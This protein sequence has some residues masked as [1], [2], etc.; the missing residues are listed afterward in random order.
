MTPET[1]RPAQ[2]ERFLIYGPT[3]LM[4]GVGR[5]NTEL[6][7]GLVEGGHQVKIL[8]TPPSVEL[9]GASNI[10][11]PRPPDGLS[12]LAKWEGFALSHVVQTL[13]EKLRENEGWSPTTILVNGKFRD[14]GPH[15]RDLFPEARLAQ[16]V[17]NL[18]YYTEHPPIDDTWAVPAFQRGFSRTLASTDMGIGVGPLLTSDLLRMAPQ[19]PALEVSPPDC[20]FVPRRCPEA[21]APRRTPPGGGATYPIPSLWSPR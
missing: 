16:I 1:S 6:V 8:T 21:P 7:R 9:E 10:E 12:G 11:L 20:G 19:N 2:P 3:T 18:S 5:F 13:D 17:H 4:D 15:I 14:V